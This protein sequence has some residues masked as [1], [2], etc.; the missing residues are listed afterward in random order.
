MKLS[1]GLA[2]TQSASAH[3]TNGDRLSVDTPMILGLQ[4][5]LQTRSFA[6]GNRTPNMIL[7]VWRQDFKYG[8][9]R[10]TKEA[11]IKCVYFN[12]SPSLRKR[13]SKVQH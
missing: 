9:S 8:L 10:V 7:C 5:W 12:F 11:G 3:E 2:L 13:V 1:Q 4:V 6:F